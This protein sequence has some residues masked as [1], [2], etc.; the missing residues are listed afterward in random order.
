[1]RQL[2]LL[3]SAQVRRSLSLRLRPSRGTQTSLHSLR[4]SGKVLA[5]I[6]EL[7]VDLLRRLSVGAAQV[8]VVLCVSWCYQPA[9]TASAQAARQQ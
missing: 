2:R 5:A 1:M 3:C 9:N 4:A 8:R 7:L 6:P